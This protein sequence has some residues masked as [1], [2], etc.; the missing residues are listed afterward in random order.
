MIETVHVPTPSRSYDVLVG[1]SILPDLGTI[2]R[3]TLGEREV[4]LIADS[5]VAALHAPTAL[6]S[7]EAAGMRTH[8]ITFPAGE[9]NKTMGTLASILEGIASAKLTRD[10]CV[11]ALGGGVTGDMAGLAAALY[12]RGIDLVQVPTSLLSMVDSSVGGK[13][14]VDIGSGKNLVGAFYQPRLVVVDVELLR[15]M[16]EELFRD[17]C[18]EVIKHAMIADAELFA[19]L[20]RH[21]LDQEDPDYDSLARVVARNIAIKRDVV[22]QDEREGGLRQ[23]LNFGHT[24]GHAVEAAL[25]FKL[26]HGACVCIGMCAI[27]R[28]INAMGIV[29]SEVLFD[30]EN[31]IK[32]FGLPTDVEVPHERVIEFMEHD[33]KRHADSF[34]VVLPVCIGEVEIARV[35]RKMMRRYVD[36]GLA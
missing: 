29:D 5:T 7:L 27:T 9:A 1:R 25:D 31:C 10:G 15:T 6:D 20:K 19:Q 35:S 3:G 11:V 18:G 28:A 21:P 30:L 12:L 4:C 14:A 33:K 23:I 16:P 36:I 26:G 22:V 32:A 13:T 8:V 17:G 24:I 2:M 34:N